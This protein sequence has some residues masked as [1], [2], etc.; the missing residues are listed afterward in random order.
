MTSISSEV[1]AHPSVQRLKRVAEALGELTGDI[2]FIGGA[3][4]PLLQLDPPFDQARVTKDVD[5][6]AVTSSYSA[7]TVLAEKL[8]ERGF[9]QLIGAS[10]VHRWQSPDNDMLDLVPAGKHL[11][12][13]GQEW[14][15]YAVESAWKADL[16]N[17]IVV[18]YASAPAFLALKFAAFRDRGSHDPFTSRDLEDIASLVASRP[19]IVDEVEGSPADVQAF[20]GE[21]IASFLTMDR[22]QDAL[23]GCFSHIQD[24]A[25]T[26]GE[27]LARFGKMA[28]G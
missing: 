28:R 23:F 6:V 24:P 18:Q 8:I 12:A 7:A 1:L 27:V 22:H 25:Y 19:N 20:I 15:E 21:Q 2:V 16:G 3:V 5:G 13:T 9:S 4:S 26:V 17:G 11:G 14:D 10:H